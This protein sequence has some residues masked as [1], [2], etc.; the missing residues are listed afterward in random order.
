MAMAR[1]CRSPS[2]VQTAAACANRLSRC[3]LRRSSPGRG[4][5]SPRKSNAT[6]GAGIGTRIIR[7]NR[8]RHYCLKSKR[9]FVRTISLLQGEWNERLRRRRPRPRNGLVGLPHG[10]HYHYSRANVWDSGIRPLS[11]GR[12]RSQ[13]SHRQR[14][15]DSTDRAACEG[16]T[17]ES[18]DPRT[19]CARHRALAADYQR[20]TNTAVPTARGDTG[21][22]DGRAKQ[23]TH[24]NDLHSVGRARNTTSRDDASGDYPLTLF[25]EQQDWSSLVP[26]KPIAV[27]PLR[28]GYYRCAVIDPPWNETG[29]G[30]I[31]RGADRHYQLL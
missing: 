22:D 21:A 16:R 7:P 18:R 13:S 27:D 1:T 30:R 11:A 17:A 3:A 25:P 10:G 19:G 12:L 14:Y 6:H 23:R 9:C 28:R 24:R 2:S 20:H 26:I 31:K 5:S 15:S 29:G 4:K 8:S